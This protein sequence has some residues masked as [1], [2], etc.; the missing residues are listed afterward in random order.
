MATIKIGDKAPDFTG[1]ANTGKAVSLSDY[2]GKKVALVIYVR[3]GSSGCKTE[4]NSIESSLKTINKIPVS[5][6]AVGKNSLEAH[7]RFAK[8]NGY[9]FPL[10]SD[11]DM[12]IIKAYGAYGHKRKVKG[13]W[14]DGV[15]RTTFLIDEDGI[16]VDVIHKVDN[17]T[18]GQQ[19]IDR[20]QAVSK[21][22]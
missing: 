17:K 4:L 3:D 6:V 10:I 16:I 7:Q 21:T 2:K 20:W 22:K 18:A 12:T 9:S 11:A 15:L 1:P 19:L 8:E 14:K 13:E 5:V